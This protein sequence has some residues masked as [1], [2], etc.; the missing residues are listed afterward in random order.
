ML[1]FFM[2]LLNVFESTEAINIQKPQLFFLFP[3]FPRVDLNEF[4]RKQRH[5]RSFSFYLPANE[6]KARFFHFFF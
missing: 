6:S 4:V 5:T 3:F 2:F 1:V